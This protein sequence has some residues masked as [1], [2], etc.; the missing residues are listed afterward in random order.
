[1]RTV[2]IALASI[3]ALASIAISTAPAY[4]QMRGKGGRH[5]GSEQQTA[6]QKQKAAEA[7]KAYK[8]A[9]D[10]TP[11]KKNPTRGG[12]CVRIRFQVHARRTASAADAP[13]RQ[14]HRDRRQPR[15]AR[16]PVAVRMT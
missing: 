8:A 7:E 9:L 14:S 2:V 1:M 4:A 16:L 13:Q 12:T 3:V 5:S 10:R 15:H 11:D 6:E